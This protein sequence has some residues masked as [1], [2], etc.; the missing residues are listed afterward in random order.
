MRLPGLLLC[1][2]WN[3]QVP[4]VGYTTVNEHTI[5]DVS[6]TPFI[7]YSVNNYQLSSVAHNR[8]HVHDLSAHAP[9]ARWNAIF[10]KCSRLGDGRSVRFVFHIPLWS[11]GCRHN[12]C[13]LA[14]AFGAV[15][16]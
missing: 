1:R 4:G 14:V 13:E 8:F 12:H 16:D 3:G 11:A 10:V 6:I 9:N 5:R 7:P 2:S 15:F